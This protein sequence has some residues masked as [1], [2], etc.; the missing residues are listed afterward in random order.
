MLLTLGF[1]TVVVLTGGLI[2]A[3]R[4]RV[5]RTALA[6]LPPRASE[7]PVATTPVESL[8]DAFGIE[9]GDVVLLR[10]GDEAWLSGALVFDEG[11]AAAVLFVGP[12]AGG[13]R[14][15]LAFRRGAAEEPDLLWLSEAPELDE[16]EG[17]HVLEHAG[18]RLERQRRRP[19]AV[20]KRGSMAP[21]V[22]ETAV[23]TEF[24]GELGGAAVI[25]RSGSK[26]LRLVGRKLHGGS[27]D[28][29]PGSE[30]T[31]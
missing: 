3:R 2:Q 31:R 7:T 29:L 11:A 22:S 4:A 1:V 28:I 18:E 14:Y 23:L 8:R 6:R 9:L 25:V 19:F 5:R 15:V 27:F 21:E 16:R 13:S 26:S 10:S 30:D 24:R 17:V 20:H 12:D